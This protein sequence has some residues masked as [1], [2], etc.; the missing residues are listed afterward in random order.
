MYPASVGSKLSQVSTTSV[1]T[2]EPWEE[3]SLWLIGLQSQR[4]GQ[5]R[6]RGRNRR[7]WR[8]EKRGKTHGVKTTCFY[9]CARRWQV[10]WDRHHKQTMMLKNISVKTQR[11]KLLKIFPWKFI[12]HVK[13]LSYWRE[14]FLFFLQVPLRETCFWTASYCVTGQQ[15]GSAGQPIGSKGQ[16]TGSGSAWHVTCLRTRT[17][18]ASLTPS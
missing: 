16:K 14:R 9:S 7:R 1:T 2:Q 8:R 5:G 13:P 4:D 12:R 18:S 6:F 15:L 17:V 3:S 10:N 11:H